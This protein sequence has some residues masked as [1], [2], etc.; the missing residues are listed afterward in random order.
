MCVYQAAA[1]HWMVTRSR[2][3]DPFIKAEQGIMDY[4]DSNTTKATIYSSFPR[5]YS[6]K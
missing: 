6:D 3:N 5:G 1:L 4:M 2:T